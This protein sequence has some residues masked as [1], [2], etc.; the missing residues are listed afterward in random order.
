[1]RRADLP[2]LLVAAI[3]IV[4]A[5]FALLRLYVIPSR[6][7]KIMRDVEERMAVVRSVDAT[8]ALPLAR[9]NLADLDRAARSRTLDPQWY[10]YCG[11]NCELLDRWQDAADAYTRALAI[12]QRP[13]LY[14]SRGLVLLHLGRIDDATADM[15]TAV[16]FNPFLLDQIGGDLRARVAAEAGRS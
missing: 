3:V 10:L 9:A 13:E 8:R 14:F 12:D 1:M 7:N 6:D 4:A 11:A 15:V 2:R 5:S 16:R